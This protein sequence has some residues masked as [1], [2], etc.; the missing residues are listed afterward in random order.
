MSSTPA[1]LPPYDLNAIFQPFCPNLLQPD[2]QQGVE[3]GSTDGDDEVSDE[4][5]KNPQASAPTSD[6]AI[7][8]TSGNDELNGTERITIDGAGKRASQVITVKNL[9]KN[10]LTVSVSEL[11]QRFDSS[12]SRPMSLYLTRTDVAPMC[13]DEPIT[14]WLLRMSGR[15]S[16]EVMRET[17]EACRR[18]NLAPE[19]VL[20]LCGRLSHSDLRVLHKAAHAVNSGR[21]YRG[22]AAC[23]LRYACEHFVEFDD[24]LWDLG[25]FPR[26]PFDNNRLVNLLRDCKLVSEDVLTTCRRDALARGITVGWSLVKNGH[27]SRQFLKVMLESLSAVSAR[28]LAYPTLIEAVKLTMCDE[29]TISGARSPE[30]LLVSKVGVTTIDRAMGNLL[31]GSRLIA[32][33]DL[34]F[35]SEIAMEEG[36]SLS[37]VISHFS[38][39]KGDLM[40]AAGSLAFMLVNNKMSARRSAELLEKIRQTGVPLSDV[41]ML[42]ND[43][44]AVAK[45]LCIS[46]DSAG[47]GNGVFHSSPTTDI[48]VD[49]PTFWNMNLNALPA[50]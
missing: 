39:I 19:E 28:K 32:M 12:N 5:N 43:N 24:A 8:S 21:I 3:N 35:C 23:A 34:L 44:Y 50:V 26:E 4:S 38:L 6:V 31:L 7:D 42:A 20:R 29:S 46:A 11:R 33:D 36:R 37:T 40:Q 15:I 22:F 18:L 41:D 16:D 13:P 45:P 47:N 25:I 17:L 9:I 27:V 1:E 49:I 14:S 48:V 30:A 2:S 10:E